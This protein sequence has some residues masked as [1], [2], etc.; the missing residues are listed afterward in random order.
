MVT[1]TKGYYM[2]E[3]C[4]TQEVYEAVMGNN[5]GAPKDPKLPVNHVDCANVYKFCEL[6]S[7]KTG[8]KVRYPTAAEWDYAA[9]VGTSNPPFEVKY[10]TQPNAWGFYEIP[11]PTWERVG[12]ATAV[13]YKDTVDPVHTPPQDRNEA[14]RG[15]QHQQTGKGKTGY[16]IG[17]FEYINSA[18]ADYRFRVVVETED[19]GAAPAAK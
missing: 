19:A 8:R 14:T 11:G 7:Q 10:R 9:R 2:A 15:Q 4:V 18:P 16:A 13:D 3:R 12:D 1:L 17:E 6:L 5:P